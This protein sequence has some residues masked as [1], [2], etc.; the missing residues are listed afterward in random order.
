MC[1]DLV[2]NRLF[3]LLDIF[4]ASFA[5]LVEFK[6]NDVFLGVGALCF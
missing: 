1:K 3:L 2:G 4:F 5:F 6:I